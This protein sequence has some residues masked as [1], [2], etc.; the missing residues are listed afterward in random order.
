MENE[1]VNYYELVSQSLK[2]K[3]YKT[4]REI[5]EDI[6]PIDIADSFN[7]TPIDEINF[8]NFII[9]FKIVK[10]EYSSDFFSELDSDLQ[11]KIIANLT[12]EQIEDLVEQ[13]STDDLADFIDDWPANVVDK[14]LKNTSKEKRELINKLLGYKDDTA[15]SIMT[16]EYVTL[17]DTDKVDVALNIIRK[18]GKNA[19]T[20][21]T[22]FVRNK[23]FD[24]VGVLNLDDLIFAEPNEILKD[25]C[26]T[27]F[28]VVNVNT[29][30]EEVAQIFKRYDLNAIGVVNE[31]NKLTGIITIDDIIDVIEEETNEDIEAMAHVTPLKDTYLDTPAYKIAFKCIP[32]LI[33]LMF[34]NI[35]SIFIQ[36][37]FQFLIGQLTAI[38]VFLTTI[39]D[40]GGNSGSQSSTLI[41]RG[42]STQEFSLKDYGKVLWKE[43]RVGI[44]VGLLV[45]IVSFGY[46]MF[47]F[48][49]HIVEIPDTFVSN[50][51]EQTWQV[52][53]ILSTTVAITLFIALLLSKLIGASLPFLATKLK[54]DPAVVS[55]PIIST[56]ADLASLGIYFG[57]LYLSFFIFNWI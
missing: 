44:L 38:S 42:L 36:N 32:W 5:F 18:I 9:L 20:I 7:E 24:L 33:I 49:C 51:N 57:L 17:F 47:L 34:L 10:P 26:D 43:L 12:N 21:Y 2:E 11:E 29:D 53:L 37:Q 48:G 39:C 4:V 50:I 52:W 54:L 30:Q 19:E 46:C 56:I 16:T 45:A 35:G 23:K 15:G 14:V 8:K 22:L 25:V 31:D 13:S 41:I 28:Q 55:G 27:T 40:S 6:P 1:R 3:K